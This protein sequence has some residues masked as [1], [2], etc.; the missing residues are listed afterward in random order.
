MQHTKGL[1]R[2]AWPVLLTPFTSDLRVD[3]DAVG[4]LVEF[5]VEQGVAGLFTNSMS[6]EVYQL[7]P[8]ERHRLAAE[9][10]HAAAGRVPVVSTAI[11]SSPASW[12]EDAK[13]VQ[14]TGVD[15]TVVITSLL[16]GEREPD[17]VWRHRLDGLLEAIPTGDLGLYECPVP[18]KRLVATDVLA[19]LAQTGRFVYFKDTCQSVPRM[20]E[21]IEAVSGTRL[22][23]F[24]AQIQSL[25]A[26]D[27]AGGDGF[28]GLA[29]NIYPRLVQWLVENDV[30]PAADEERIVAAQRLLSIAESSIGSNY[31][32]SAK[33]VVA[34]AH[35]APIEVWSRMGQAA[36]MTAHQTD[37]LLDLAAYLRSA[38]FDGADLPLA[39]E[40]QALA[41]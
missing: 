3:F 2:G 8:W 28:S 38:G 40:Q 27:R 16:A 9:V 10:V 37:P 14:D 4:P 24:N 11:G 31:P 25:V 29:A 15:A 22:S 30:D 6:S 19:E 13:A 23:F 1:P 20:T 18:Y 21:R 12:A 5:Y 35:G 33:F 34:R 17:S 26:T 36:T 41:L 32:S 39:A 7:H